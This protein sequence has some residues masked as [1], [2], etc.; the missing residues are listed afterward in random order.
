MQKNPQKSA[1][2][3]LDFAI[4]CFIW[5]WAQWQ[6]TLNFFPLGAEPP[7]LVQAPP[8]YLHQ[9]LKLAAF[10]TLYSLENVNISAE[11]PLFSSA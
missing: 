3:T 7:S 1:L 2:E 4:K 5:P 8:S 9:Q 6:Q 11:I 10:Q